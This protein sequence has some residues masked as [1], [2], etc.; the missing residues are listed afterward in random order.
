M[1]LHVELRVT[2]RARRR[3]GVSGRL[4]W[5]TM[6]RLRI[7]RRHINMAH[8]E[9]G[10]ALAACNVPQSCRLVIRSGRQRLS[11]NTKCNTAD[12]FRVSLKERNTVRITAHVAV[13]VMCN[14]RV[15]L[16]EPGS[17]STCQVRGSGTR[18]ST[19]TTNG[20][21]DIQGC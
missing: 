11:V 18:P 20:F 14:V 16:T 2:V 10:R 4:R 17:G 7:L 5:Y 13:R 12:I 21:V 8:L 9:G 15:M 6:C 19:T 1:R 3:N